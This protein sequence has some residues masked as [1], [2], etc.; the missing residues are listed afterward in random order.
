MDWT[1]KLAKGRSKIAFDLGY[2]R[3]N[4]V[5][6]EENSGGRGRKTKAVL[7]VADTTLGAKKTLFELPFEAGYDWAREAKVAGVGK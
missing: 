5:S 4:T 2:A 1:S 7:E 6:H 3:E